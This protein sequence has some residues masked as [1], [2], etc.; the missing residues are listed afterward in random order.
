[1][2]YFVN[3]N[4]DLAN[5]ICTLTTF[6]PHETTLRNLSIVILPKRKP[7]P[8]N[9]ATTVHDRT[10]SELSHRVL[11]SERPSNAERIRVSTQLLATC[12]LNSQTNSRAPQNSARQPP[13]HPERKMHLQSGC[14]LRNIATSAQATIAI[15]HDPRLTQTY[16]HCGN[17]NNPTYIQTQ[18]NPS[19]RT[20]LDALCS[21][22]S[23]VLIMLHQTARLPSRAHNPYPTTPHSATDTELSQHLDNV[24]RATLSNET[25]RA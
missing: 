22:L 9:Y 2:A 7:Q 23:M 12:G 24:I 3:C 13:T 6:T 11:A 1:M 19:R 5:P 15:R 25:L 14:L 20:L 17:M 4:V 8:R 21:S 16:K 10:K 18:A